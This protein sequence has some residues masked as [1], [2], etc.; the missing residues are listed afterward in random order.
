MTKYKFNLEQLFYALLATFV[1]VSFCHLALVC[2]YADSEIWLLTLSQQTFHKGQLSS[3][4]Y[5][6]AFHAL[7]YLFSHHAPNELAVYTYARSG[8]M[9]I[10][11]IA[12]LATAYAFSSFANQKKLFL[13]LFI[14]VMTFSAFFNQGFRVRGDTLSLFS[15]MVIMAGLFY[16]KDQ[17]IRFWHYLA[18][19]VF[20]LILALSTP[21]SIFLYISQFAFALAMTFYLRLPRRFYVFIWISH[22][23]PL[24]LTCALIAI[25]YF[26]GDPLSLMAAVHE[27]M[28]YY[29][30]SFDA[31]LWNAGFFTVH[32]FSHVIKAFTKSSAHALVFLIGACVYLYTSYRS[33]KITIYTCLNV[34]GGTLFLFVLLHNQ[35]L[36]FFLGTYG[37]PLIAYSFLLTYNLMSSVFKSY[38]RFANMILIGTMT[39]FC[40]LDCGLNLNHN[41]N[42]SQ[43]MAIDIF[44]KYVQKHPQTT[45]YDTIGILPRKNTLFLFVG[46]G[47]VSRK[48]Q[49]IADLH[50]ANP[51][52]ILYTFKFNYLEPDIRHYLLANR[53]QP[54]PN[55]WVNGDHFSLAKNTK[56]FEKDVMLRGIPHWLVPARPGKYVYEFHSGNEITHEVIPFKD[57]L[58][59][60]RFEQADSFAI[61]RKY[62]D[63]FQTNV[64]PIYFIQTPYNLFRY[65]TD[66]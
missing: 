32:D 60:K 62:I 35:K 41:N 47:E 31:K 52:F 27:A 53:V 18:L 37:T 6:W 13:P 21:K 9:I 58:E 65:D 42:M 5:K 11:L 64:E 7:T 19:F 23:S 54:T 3:I 17:P 63:F 8:W 38:S 25:S 29:L 48:K 44:D 57:G 20:N 50:A 61:P 66:F 24:V 26:V 4:L 39:F 55:V 28:D 34:Y 1:A 56:H 12:Q 40:V 59:T 46:P 10:A 43:Q 22:I 30:K 15:H 16:I 14:A 33:K 2:Y 45:Y 49:I 51:T 36:P